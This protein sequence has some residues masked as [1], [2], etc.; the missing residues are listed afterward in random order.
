MPYQI[1]SPAETAFNTLAACLL[2]LCFPMPQVL[3]RTGMQV[4]QYVAFDTDEE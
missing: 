4:R 3:P 2:G 1:E